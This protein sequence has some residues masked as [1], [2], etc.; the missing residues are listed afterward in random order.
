[1]LNLVL[2]N[3]LVFVVVLV[4]LLVSVAIHEAAHAYTADFLGDPTARA[5]GR[6]TLNPLAHIDITGLLF[7]IFWGFGW[8]KPVPYDSFNLRRP[9]RDAAIIALA[10]PLSS[11]A[12]AV[13]VSLLL[14]VAP[15]LFLENLL[16]YVVLL[17]TTL[18]IFNLVPIY[19]LDGFSVLAGILPEEHRDDWNKLS[20]YGIVI[21]LLFLLPIAGGQSPLFILIQPIIDKIVGF[22][23]PGGII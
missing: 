8:G 22:L 21:L 9:S 11:L 1:M 20:Q 17:N 7:L 6:L 3:P 13:L 10:G 14:R 5:M 18:A 4:V 12:F 16:E 15:W 2:T 19:P 23:L